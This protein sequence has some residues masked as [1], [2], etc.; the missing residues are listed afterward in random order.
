VIRGRGE[1][2]WLR[3]AALALAAVG[4]SGCTRPAAD[5]LLFVS[6]DTTRA[7]H[8]S[9][10]GYSRVTS[11]TVDGL[12]ERGALFTSAY[13]HV[14]STL[15]AHSTMFTGLLPPQHG[16]RCNGKFR[17][18]ESR[19]T[20]AEILA[21]AGFDT[22]A[23]V[24]AFP[25]AKR[26][27]IAQGFTTYDDDFATSALTAK[28]RKGRMDNPGFWIG[29]EFVDFERGADEVTDRA[30]NWLEG[31]KPR[32]FLFAHYFDAHWP[33]EPAE[34]W[35]P[36]YESPYDAEIAY[37]DAHLGRLLDK[38]ATM[39]GRTLIVFTADHG[40]GLGDHGEAMH[41]RFLYDTTIR[42]P[43]VMALDGAV[44]ANRRI[45]ASV[46]HVDLLP[47]VLEFLGVPV[48][49][50]LAGRSL[51]PLLNGGVLPARPVYAETLVPKLERPLGIEVRAWIEA[52]YKLTRTE[53]PAGERVELYNLVADPGE[54]T[55]LSRSQEGVAAR[56]GER[57]A[58]E[59][60]RL[61]NSAPTPE[62]IVVDPATEARLKS[63]GYL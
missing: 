27:G 7:D 45:D 39:P 51:V 4:A 57:L 16:V 33:Y 62:S 2:C 32:W 55:D 34:G 53:T 31:R 42:V 61:E 21:D 19:R 58:T 60:D 9:A 10:Y 23:V 47:T 38:V 41:N 50:G 3:A 54:L 43:L 40:E 26:F 22:G 36:M 6:F 35:G 12:A 25:M 14:P 11:P 20:L 17:L 49:E 44:Q 48:P 30:I 52:P 1:R 18:P 15:P 13:S 5:N 59:R 37:A 28:R 24:G 56:M 29:H 46:G 63:L 8:L